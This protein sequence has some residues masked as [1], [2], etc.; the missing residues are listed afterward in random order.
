MGNVKGWKCRNK[1][2]CLFRYWGLSITGDTLPFDDSIMV[3]VD[4]LDQVVSA[5][6]DAIAKRRRRGWGVGPPPTRWLLT[7]YVPERPLVASVSN[8]H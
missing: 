8:L 7:G 2:L 6:N 1:V 3:E 5:F 4:F